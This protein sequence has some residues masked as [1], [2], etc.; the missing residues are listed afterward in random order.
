MDSRDKHLGMDR[1][2]TRRDFIGGVS[3]AIGASLLPACARNGEPVVTESPSVY[4]PPGEVGLR[5]S[6]PGSFE[7]AHAT[8]EGAQWTAEKLDEHYDSSSS[9]FSSSSVRVSAVWRPRT[10]I[11]AT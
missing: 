8:V 6:H 3:I 10:S 5:G 7:V 4:Y 11:V 1:E 2:I 9:V